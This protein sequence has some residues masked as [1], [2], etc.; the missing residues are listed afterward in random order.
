ME[1][2][3]SGNYFK[4]LWI[5]YAIIFFHQLCNEFL[6]KLKWFLNTKQKGSFVLKKL[7]ESRDETAT[8]LLKFITKIFKFTLDGITIA[9]VPFKGDGYKHNVEHVQMHRLIIFESR[10]RQGKEEKKHRVN[11]IRRCINFSWSTFE[12]VKS[13][14]KRETRN[15]RKK[16]KTILSGHLLWI[17]ESNKG[18]F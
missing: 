6:F 11:N 1:K 9:C 3:F 5:D 13:N 14:R 4:S 18:I 15:E 12:T 7:H 17:K 2:V 16:K 8:K 10:K